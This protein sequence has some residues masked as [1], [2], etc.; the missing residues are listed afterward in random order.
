MNRYCVKVAGVAQQGAGYN[1]ILR[2]PEQTARL[3]RQQAVADVELGI[4]DGRFISVQ[5]R[6]KIYATLRDIAEYTGYPDEDMKQIMKVEHVMQ[7][8]L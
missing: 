4:D 8:W 1:L 6:R 7:L 2:V 3:I 5:Q